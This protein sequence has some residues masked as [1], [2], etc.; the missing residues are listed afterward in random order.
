MPVRGV[1]GATTA[2]ENNRDAILDAT[3]ELLQ[4]M[5]ALNQIDKNDIAS[6][7]FS[8]TPDLDAEYPATAAR[9][10]LDWHKVPLFGQCEIA[11]PSGISKCIRVL[12][13]WN[14]T[15]AADEIQFTYLR[16]TSHLRTDDNAR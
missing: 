10:R 16:G 7:F 8:I 14:T 4:E 11:P 3:A 13:L 5:V 12:I 15:K 6:V 9:L 2:S 1:R